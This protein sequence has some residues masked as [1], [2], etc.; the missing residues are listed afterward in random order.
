MNGD[1]TSEQQRFPSKDFQILILVV[2]L[3]AFF[4]PPI[5][6]QVNRFTERRRIDEISIGR[7]DKAGGWRAVEKASLAFAK[8]LGPTNYFHQYYYWRGKRLSTN[9]LPATLDT[10]QPW[11]I[12]LEPDANGIPVMR[13]HLFGVHRTGT[14]D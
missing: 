13:M 7:V 12:Y 1:K 2:L 9:E 8:E 5:L 14:Y 4:G 11:I 10:L 3:L 6:D